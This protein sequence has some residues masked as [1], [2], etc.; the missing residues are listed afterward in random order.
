MER[1]GQFRNTVD[2]TLTRNMS[3]CHHQQPTKMKGQKK[4]AYNRQQREHNTGNSL[5]L[6]PWVVFLDR[7]AV[8]KIKR[9]DDDD[10]DILSADKAR[11]VLKERQTFGI[12]LP[13]ITFCFSRL[14]SEI[15][16]AWL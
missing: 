16:Q 6:V 5:L 13:Q 8:W 10:G 1:F 4:E 12:D 3:T 14:G 9:D 11:T 2:S 15:L 7:A